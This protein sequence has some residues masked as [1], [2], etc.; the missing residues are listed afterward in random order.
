MT[1]NSGDI[2]T[3]A[4]TPE[5][6]LAMP[7]AVTHRVR[8]ASAEEPFVFLITQTPYEHYDFITR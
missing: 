5:S 2:E 3:Y 6:F 8:N 7:P 4:L 1:T